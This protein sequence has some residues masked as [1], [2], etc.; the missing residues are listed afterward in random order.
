MMGCN[1]SKGILS[2][3]YP[4]K[5]GYV[6]DI[7]GNYDY[8]NRYIQLSEVVRRDPVTNKLLLQ[9]RC[10]LVF[11]GDVCDR[12]PG[13]IRIT[14][15]LIELKEKYNERVHFILGNRDVN[16]FRIRPELQLALLQRPPIAYWL[17]DKPVENK[18]ICKSLINYKSGF[19]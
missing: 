2:S 18:V 7:E 19:N 17:K 3:S 4:F 16:K 6:T 9:D 13:D 12:G 5:I 11:G 8:W 1:M 10:W 15:D 14:R